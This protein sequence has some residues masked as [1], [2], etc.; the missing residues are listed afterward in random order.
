MTSEAEKPHH[1]LPR[2]D[3]ARHD[4]L[5]ESIENERG[6]GDDDPGASKPSTTEPPAREY[7]DPDGRPYST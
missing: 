2:D 5:P 7:R 1:P 6:L 3:R 4:I